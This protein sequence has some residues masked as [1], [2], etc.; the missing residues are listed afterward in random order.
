MME[1]SLLG[2]LGLRIYS[3]YRIMRLSE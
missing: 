3:Y 2:I 1:A